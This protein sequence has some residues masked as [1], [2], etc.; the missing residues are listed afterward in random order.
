MTSCLCKAL[1]GCFLSVGWGSGDE[2]HYCGPR[3]NLAGRFAVNISNRKQT[4]EEEI[5]NN[6]AKL[7]CVV[8]EIVPAI[9]GRLWEGKSWEVISGLVLKAILQ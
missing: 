1:S 5:A 2:R 6:S 7:Q 9:E 3:E 8:K 4:R